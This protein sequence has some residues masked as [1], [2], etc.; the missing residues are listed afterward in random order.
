MMQ[1]N[2]HSFDDFAPEAD[3]VEQLIPVAVDEDDE[4]ALDPVLTRISP[5]ADADEAD[6][7][8]QAMVVP[9]DDELAFER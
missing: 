2:D 5:S 3:A 6:L 7:L 8:E 9:L 4:A 1:A